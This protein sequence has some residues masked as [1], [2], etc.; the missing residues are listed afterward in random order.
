MQTMQTQPNTLPDRPR[1]PI[2]PLLKLGVALLLLLCLADMP[3]GFFTLVRFVVAATFAYMAYDYFK[4]NKDGMGF[5]FAALALL[6]QPFY[7]FAL[8]RAVW[9]FVDIVVAVGLGW[10]IYKTFKQKD[11]P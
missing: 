5:T 3:Y 6:F 11:R 7:K 2:S 4:A 9:H 1:K 10:L 8:G